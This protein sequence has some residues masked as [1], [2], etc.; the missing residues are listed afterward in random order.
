MPKRFVQ[1]ILA[2]IFL[3]AGILHFTMDDLFAQIVP[4]VLPWPFLIVWTTGAIELAFG[5]LLLAGRSLHTVSVLLPLY[6]LAVLPANIYMALEEITFGNEAVTPSFLWV[7]V[8]L[9]F[10]L[11]AL[12]VWATRR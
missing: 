11:I 2:A 4:P 8:A 3:T 7:R 1:I 6:L 9:Q 5:T 12:V 10:P